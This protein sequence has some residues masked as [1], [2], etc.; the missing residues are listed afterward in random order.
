MSRVLSDE[1]S[2]DVKEQLL[3]FDVLDALRDFIGSDPLKHYLCDFMENTAQNIQ[4]IGIAIASDD[5]QDVRQ[6]AHKLKGSSGNIGALKLAWQCV[7]L[8]ALSVQESSPEELVAQYQ[9]LEQVYHDTQ[10]ALH[11]Y[12]DAL[13]ITQETIV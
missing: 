12:V 10:A 1:V 3:E 2:S 13:A 7:E 4:R 11:S 6:L 5:D 9:Q 8:E